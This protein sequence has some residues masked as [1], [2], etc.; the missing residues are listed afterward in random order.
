MYDMLLMA[1]GHFVTACNAEWTAPGMDPMLPWA[2]IFMADWIRGL[3]PDHVFLTMMSQ[4]DA[5]YAA[6]AECMVKAQ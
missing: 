3:I 4:I 5:N 1:F 2:G 6:L